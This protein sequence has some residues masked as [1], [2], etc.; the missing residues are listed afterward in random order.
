VTFG[1]TDLFS[2]SQ[3]D[4]PEVS[5][6]GFELTM[7]I[8]ITG[9]QPPAWALRLLQQLGRYVYSSGRPLAAGHRL[10]P[11]GPITGAADTNLTA[12]AFAPDPQLSE[13]STANGLVRFVTVV[14]I[15]G[16]EL[17]RMKQASTAAVLA[18]LSAASPLLI[19]D[20]RS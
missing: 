16:E 1:L 10:D 18:E 17:A 3:G 2:K 19:T 12:V 4:D 6:W 13:I 9:D 14:G 8:P 5:G 7:R 11:D 15:T 20:P